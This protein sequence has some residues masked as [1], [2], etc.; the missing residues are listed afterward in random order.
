M[1][2][3]EYWSVLLA[4]ANPCIKLTIAIITTKHLLHDDDLSACRYQYRLVIDGKNQLWAES[5][6]N[7]YTFNYL[8]LG[9]STVYVCAKDPSA[10]SACAYTQVEVLPAPADFDASAAIAGMNIDD[11]A[12]SH[13]I[14]AAGDG[15][16]KLSV[17]SEGASSSSG[18]RRLLAATCPDS[19]TRDTIASKT[20][21]LLALLSNL[22]SGLQQD[23]AAMRQVR[24]MRVGNYCCCSNW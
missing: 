9:I 17:L 10:A 4:C 24:C 7:S 3:T 15:V 18:R 19:E 8:P 23:P 5:D 13:D 22:A 1:L 20:T 2:Q 21:Q 6:G 14:D 16:N 12:G 11:I